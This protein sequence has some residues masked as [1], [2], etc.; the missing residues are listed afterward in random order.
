MTESILAHSLRIE[1]FPNVALC[2]DIANK[3]KF[4]YRTNSEKMV[5]KFF[6]KFKKPY[7]GPFSPFLRQKKFSEKSGSTSYGFLTPC[8]NLKKPPTNPIPKEKRPER[9]TDRQTNPI[10]LDPFGFCGGSNK[11]INVMSVVQMLRC[12][13]H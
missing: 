3:I 12:L 10:L 9:L 13:H 7:F 1:L 4:H 11:K 8:H 6:N 2:M 5:P